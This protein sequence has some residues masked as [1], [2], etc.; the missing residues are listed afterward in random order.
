MGGGIPPLLGGFM[1]IGDLFLLG[2]LVPT[3]TSSLTI[4]VLSNVS[5]LKL[6]ERSSLQFECALLILLV[7]N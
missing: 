1:V 5:P 6:E 3:K 4:L 7:M 2:S